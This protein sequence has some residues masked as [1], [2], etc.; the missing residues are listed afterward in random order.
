MKKLLLLSLMVAAVACGVDK[1]KLLLASDHNPD[2]FE[3]EIAD[4]VKGFIAEAQHLSDLY[5]EMEDRWDGAAQ[6]ERLCDLIDDRVIDRYNSSTE[7]TFRDAFKYYA[8]RPGEMQR[9]AKAMLAKY[10]ALRISLSDYVQTTDRDDY[11]SW[12]FTEQRTSV[13]FL[14]EIDMRADSKPEDYDFVWSV[15]PDEDSYIAYF[16]KL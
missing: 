3:T 8:G 11:K 9:H 13:K 1:K 16:N 15:S 10:D 7:I 2:N 6:F 14:F 5:Y 4:A 12:T